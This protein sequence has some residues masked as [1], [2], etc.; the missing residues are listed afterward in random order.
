MEAL[1][2]GHVR[3]QRRDVPFE[4][5]H[6]SHRLQARERVV[7]ADE[8]HGSHVMKNDERSVHFWLSVLSRYRFSGGMI[9]SAVE[10]AL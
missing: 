10:N 5:W 1:V 2:I 3:G 9:F 6:E 7:C 8:V 4:T